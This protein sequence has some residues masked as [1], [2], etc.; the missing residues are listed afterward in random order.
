MHKNSSAL[1]VAEMHGVNVTTDVPR[2]PEEPQNFPQF[3]A[4]FAAHG[5]SLH[6]I[7]RTQTDPKGP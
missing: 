6:G 4:A 7:E 2:N 1:G 3:C 5:A